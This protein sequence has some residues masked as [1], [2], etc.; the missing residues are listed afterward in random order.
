[1]VGLLPSAASLSPLPEQATDHQLLRA[2]HE[3]IQLLPE[4]VE[5]KSGL[6]SAA[7]S[8]LEPSAE[9]MTEVQR[10]LGAV[11]GAQLAPP[12]DEV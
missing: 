6:A 9:E 7:A 5:M 10:L 8:S 1:M 12:S 11:V 4:L 2:E 3:G